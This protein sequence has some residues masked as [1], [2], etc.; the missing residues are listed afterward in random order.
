MISSSITKMSGTVVEPYVP[1]ADVSGSMT[2]DPM[3]VSI[4]MA[5]LV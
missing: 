4:G 5:I 3:S 1:M 2:G